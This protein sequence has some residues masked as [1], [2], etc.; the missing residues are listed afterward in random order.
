[1]QQHLIFPKKIQHLF[2]FLFWFSG[3]DEHPAHLP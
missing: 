1:M 3:G 2:V